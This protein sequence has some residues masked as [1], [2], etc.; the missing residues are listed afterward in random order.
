[1]LATVAIWLGLLNGAMAQSFLTV[2]K[3]VPPPITPKFAPASEGVYLPL[4]P[5]SPVDAPPRAFNQGHLGLVPQPVLDNIVTVQGFADGENDLPIRPDLP[6]IERMFMR[7]SEADFFNRLRQEAKRTPGS[8]AVIF[9]TQTPISKESY[10][11]FAFPRI[12]PQTKQPY[13]ERVCIAEPSY[14]CHRRLLFEQPNFERAG[15]NFGILQP[16][17]SLGVFYYDLAFLPYHFWSDLHDRG[18]CSVGKCLPGDPYAPMLLQ[19]ERFSVTGA[20]GQATAILGG[21]FIVP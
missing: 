9:P 20:I 11:Q 3:L 15:Y 2:D 10:V 14:V 12:D 19:R 7:D 5:A 17:M 18:E 6:G 8:A 4:P 21:V 1:M 16:W 13:Q